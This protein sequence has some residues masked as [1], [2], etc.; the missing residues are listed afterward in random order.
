MKECFWVV[1]CEQNR[2]PM[3]KHPTERLAM[4]EA[5]RLARLH[6]GD[7]FHVLKLIGS[8]TA[9]DVVWTIPTT[10]DDIPF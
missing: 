6:R 8:C 2:N 3:C 5:E 1:W 7:I 9:S 10:E 4:L